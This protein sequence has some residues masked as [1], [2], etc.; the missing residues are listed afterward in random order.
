MLSPSGREIERGLPPQGLSIGCNDL[1]IFEQPELLNSL[2]IV[3]QRSK[4]KRGKGSYHPCLF[5]YLI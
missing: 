3:W 4:T 5:S 1:T 2:L